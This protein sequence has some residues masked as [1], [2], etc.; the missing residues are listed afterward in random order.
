MLPGTAV[1]ELKTHLE[2]VRRLHQRDLADG[3]GRVALP[4]AYDRGGLH[5]TRVVVSEALG[6]HRTRPL[7]MLAVLGIAY[8]GFSRACGMSLCDVAGVNYQSQAMLAHA[9]VAAVGLS[10]A[11]LLVAHLAR[12]Q[13]ASRLG[14]RCTLLG[15]AGVVAGVL[16]VTLAYSAAAR[17]TCDSQPIRRPDGSMASVC[18]VYEPRPL[19]GS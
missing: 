16:V 15:G 12:K 14:W 17:W 9:L 4:G 2:R 13:P 19:L 6:Y 7:W 11:T 1:P 10:P 5:G 18:E 3:G 8:W